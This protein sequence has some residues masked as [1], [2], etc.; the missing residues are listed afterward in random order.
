MSQSM[1]SHS[2]ALTPA[3]LNP[4][5]PEPAG[6]PPGKLMNRNFLLL[7]QG[8]AV[9]QIGTQ[10]STIAMLFW[11]KHA[12]ESPVLMGAMQMTAG[13]VGVLL[14]PIG[15]A[16]ADRY[17]RRNIIILSD[18][19]SGF[20][21]LSLAALMFLAPAA[22]GVTLAWV[23][24][25]SIILSAVGS[26]FMPAISAAVPDLAP[27]EKV[28][29]ANSMLQASMQLAS[30]IGQGVG[31]TIFRLLGAPMVFLIDGVTYLLSALSECFIRLPQPAVKK[32]GDWRT[33]MGEFKQ[34]IREGV[35]YVRG[36]RGLVQLLS[37]TTLLN[38]FMSPILGL[39]PF[40]IEGH[41]GLQPDWFGYLLT[42]YG[43]GTLLGY[44]LAGGLP[45]SS[46]NR[47]RLM[48]GFMLLESVLYGVLGLLK[49]P[50]AVAALAAGAGATSG[51]V[52]VN[53]STILQ[54]TTP[55]EIRGRVF[56]LL[57]TVS[58]CIM[59]LGMGLAGAAAWLANNNVS[60]IYVACG[61]CMALVTLGAAS[62]GE[63]RR[64]LAYEAREP[65]SPE[66]E[67]QP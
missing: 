11:L 43:V 49:S 35:D 66:T 63:F 15:G 64:Y 29:G 40:Y 28:A 13:L 20:A 56:G 31:G 45:V 26:F 38:F 4:P 57:A 10:V 61:I 2:E 60:V 48:I 52:M 1:T 44:V 21:V 65:E 8:Q 37:A 54:L 23:F 47:G 25:V 67:P 62:L 17:S 42:I 12:T 14:G 19:L 7:W 16:F 39:F 46:R 41:L 30:L 6:A 22:T 9:S 59:P 53:V 50:G 32:T 5:V 51:F 36:N 33:Q 24:V 55:N 58:A 18:L 34:E 27:P 3:P